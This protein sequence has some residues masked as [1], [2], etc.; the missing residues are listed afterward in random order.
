MASEVSGFRTICVKFNEKCSSYHFL[1]CKRHSTRDEDAK[2]PPDKT[3]FVVNI[4]PYCT[5]GALKRLFSCCGAIKDV[6]LVKQP[7]S[8]EKET[9]SL[10][11]PSQKVKG[12]KVGYI[13]F[14]K[15]SSINTALALDSS[16]IR[17]LSTTNQPVITGMKK[18]I[19]EYYQ[20]YPDTTNLQA[21]IDE[22]MAKFDEN[23]E[24]MDKEAAEALNQPDDEGWVTVGRSGRNP[25]A[26]RLDPAELEEKRKKKKKRALLNFYQFQQRESRREHIANLRKKFDEDK[27][28]IAEMKSARKFRPY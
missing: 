11:I 6:Y 25:A 28:R 20:Q 22:F 24:Q 16:T 21:E 1:F 12:F 13:V 2:K 8:E 17:V 7:G 4:P 3:L 19:Q 10:V 5:K 9:T 23:K 15:S 18:W 14:K 26:P 27:K